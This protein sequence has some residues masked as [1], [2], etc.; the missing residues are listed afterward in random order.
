MPDA[1]VP[2]VWTEPFRVR[3]VE[4]GPDER[5]SVL[6]V[7][8]FF[9]EAA[10][11]HARAAGVEAFT[12]DGGAGTWVLHRLRLRVERLPAVRQAVVVETW[13]SAY[14]GLRASRDF[15]LHAAD[16]SALARGTSV[17]LVMHA[18]RR[19]PVRLPPAVLR[20][21]PAGRARALTFGPEPA[22]P[23]SVEAERTF[24]VRRSDL[25]R[26]GHANNVRFVEW[27]LEALDTDDGLREVDVLYR[28][29]AVWGDA[30]VSRAGPLVG[31]ARAHE[32]VRE[33]DGRTLALARTVW[34]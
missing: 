28:A 16:G 3:A 29:E 12:L 8:D 6:T 31:D 33:A 24:A 20:F 21:G 32:L 11:E 5:A 15:V 13:P 2:D 7:A 34:T 19:R 1:E 4:V 9:Q 25:D 14:D 23:S 27:A 10:G 22:A 17:W 26:V 18:A 30:V